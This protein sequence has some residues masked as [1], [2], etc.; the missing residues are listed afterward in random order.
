MEKSIDCNSVKEIYG[1]KVTIIQVS[2][3]SF[4]NLNRPIK[5]DIEGTPIKANKHKAKQAENT[6]KRLNVFVKNLEN[7]ITT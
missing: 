5:A 7:T 2:H 6:I 3:L 4:S 1:L